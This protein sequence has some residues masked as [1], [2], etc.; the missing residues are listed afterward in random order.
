MTT[1]H[2]A[3][4]TGLDPRTGT[5]SIDGKPVLQAW[6]PGG[7][8]VS[9]LICGRQAAGKTEMARWLAREHTASGVA[10]T[11]VAGPD[12]TSPI[13]WDG[14][15]DAAS[16]VDATLRML[17]SAYA[18]MRHRLALRPGFTPA[19]GLPLLRVI[20]DNADLLLADHRHGR[21]AGM[22]CAD[23]ARAG[24]AGIAVDAVLYDPPPAGS[25]PWWHAAATIVPMFA[26]HI[27][28]LPGGDALVPA[29]GAPVPAGLG[30]AL[31]AGS[32]HAAKWTFA[33]LAQ[34]VTDS[35]E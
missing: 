20:V 28:G 10:V 19:A 11:W 15:A 29:V 18:V 22:L 12:G 7:R 32:A 24:L 23:L 14:H 21:E 27:T 4:G 5:L 6:W 34:S 13:L 8:A 9:T 17:W 2:V 35:T 16:G 3:T 26:G 1:M 25:G 31:D 30:A 33:E